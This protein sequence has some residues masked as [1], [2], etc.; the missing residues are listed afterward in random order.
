M[1]NWIQAH[2]TEKCGSFVCI[3]DTAAKYL[4]I[5]LTLQLCL[6]LNLLRAE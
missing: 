2:S 1:Q 4:K 6:V 5:S 3:A